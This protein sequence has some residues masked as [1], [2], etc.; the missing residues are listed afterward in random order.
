MEADD[1]RD[2]APYVPAHAQNPAAMIN[3]QLPGTPDHVIYPT[4]NRFDAQPFDNR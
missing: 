1:Y 3:E 2:A 4:L